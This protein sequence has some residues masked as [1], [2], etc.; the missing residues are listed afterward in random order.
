MIEERA[1]TSRHETCPIQGGPVSLNDVAQEMQVISDTMTVYFK[2]STGEFLAITD[3][4]VRVLERE[5]PNEDRHEWEQE[6][7]QMTAEVLAHESNGDYV[8]L[9]SR[10]DIHEYSIME[11]FCHTV[12]NPK[13]ANDLYRSISGKGAFRRF[14]DAIFRHSIE[15][16]WYRYKDAAFKE[17]ARQ[18]CKENCITWCE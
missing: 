15:E 14:K 6:I 17:I 4:Y 1:A 12:K 18:W 8:P 10:Y 13:A 3:E 11:D 16:D 2:R 7:I 9:P 5:G